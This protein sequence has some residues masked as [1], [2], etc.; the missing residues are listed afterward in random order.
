MLIFMKTA[1]VIGGS[2]L[3]GT[4]LLN[5]LQN[6]STFDQVISIE[7]NPAHQVI[8]SKILSLLF[9]FENW[10][11]LNQQLKS[12]IKNKNCIFFC[13]LGT[14][15]K[16][17]K[18]EEAFK[19]VDF[20]YIV[21]FAELATNCQA[22]QLIVVSAYGANTASSVFYNKTKGQTEIAVQSAFNQE[23]TFLR[24]SLLLGKR[25]EFRLFEKIAVMLSPFYKRLLVGRLAE[26]QPIEAESVARVMLLKSIGQL[27][28]KALFIE[29]IELHKLT[30]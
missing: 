27:N 26:A 16:K 3:V 19:K 23:L 25:K 10:S 5:L 13:S 4:Q 9:N 24:P 22:Q 11:E 18:S 29:N 1:V 30:S 2:G 17:A 12:I 21:K 7:R 28:L 6:E 14:T 20:E 15:L 8:H